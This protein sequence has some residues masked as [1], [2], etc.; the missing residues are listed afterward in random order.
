MIGIVDPDG[1]ISSTL[2]PQTGKVERDYIPRIIA[3]GKREISGPF[4]AGATGEMIYTQ[5]MPAKQTG[6]VVSI[7]F[8]STHWNN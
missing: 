7:C 2:R 5:F 8:V 4:P 3:T 6:K 1:T